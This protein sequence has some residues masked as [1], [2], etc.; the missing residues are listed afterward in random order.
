MIKTSRRDWIAGAMA[1]TALLYAGSAAAQAYP[2]RPVR[3]IVPYA[4]GGGTDVFSRLLAAQMER[5]F[6]P[7][8]DHRQPRRRRQH[9]R[10]PG[11]GERT[12]RRLHDRDG[13]QRLRDQSRPVQGQAALRHAPRFHPGVVAIA[14]ATGVVREPVLAVQDRAGA[15]RVCQGQS[16]QADI[17]IGRH[18][19]RHSPRRRA[20]PAGDGDRDRDHPLPRRRSSAR[21]FP[22]GQ[23]R[24]HVRG[25]SQHSRAHV[26]RKG[27]WI[28]YDARARAA[29]AGYSEHGG[30]RLRQR[31]LPRARWA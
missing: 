10:H 11:G 19:N 28:G 15:D 12:A 31:R 4:P 8:A 29:A 26:G 27:A 2:Q 18:R 14:D 17:C 3:V 20:V 23:G 24:L 16:G 6:R 9:H 1:S 13:R 22:V 5:E 21:G 30:A 25:G 7:D